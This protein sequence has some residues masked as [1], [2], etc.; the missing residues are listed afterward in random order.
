MI[1]TASNAVVGTIVLDPLGTLPPFTP[2]DLEVTPNGAFL[3]VTNSSHNTVSVFRTTDDLLLAEVPV[4]RQPGG[5]AITPNGALVFVAN[6]AD[7]TV[8]FASNPILFQVS[9]MIASSLS[10]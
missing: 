4:G 8:G 6:A 3:Y 7:S 9:T 1:A 5:L 2:I 10:Y